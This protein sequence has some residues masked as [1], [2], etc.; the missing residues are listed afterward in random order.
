MVGRGCS[1]AAEPAKR[2][3]HAFA[4][5][6]LLPCRWR[7]LALQ[8]RNLALR[9]LLVLTQLE[10]CQRR[11]AGVLPASTALESAAL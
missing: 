5:A 10:P 1:I 3:P 8:G 4:R 6:L 9:A 11:A 7:N 2:L